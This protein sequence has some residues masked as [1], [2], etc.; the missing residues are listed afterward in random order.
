M[1]ITPDTL[2]YLHGFAG[3][4]AGAIIAWAIAM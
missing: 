1:E 4:I 3:I 2:V